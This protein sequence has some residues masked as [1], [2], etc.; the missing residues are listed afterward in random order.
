MSGTQTLRHLVREDVARELVYTAR[1]VSGTE[2][3]ALG[4]ATRTSDTPYE[5]A[6][7]L[8][9]EIAARSP[10]A[11]RA[12]KRLLDSTR[13]L[14]TAEGLRLEEEIQ[15]TVIGKPN[16]LEAVRANMEKREP[17]FEDPA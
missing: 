14:G 9:R 15:R 10:D 6:H 4:L 13:T 17:K 8:A 2:A 12:A 11:V 16:Q 7:E 1:T 3:V 5:A